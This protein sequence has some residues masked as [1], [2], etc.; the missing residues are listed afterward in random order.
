[1]N[2]T[3]VPGLFSVTL[4]SSCGVLRLVLRAGLGRRDRELD[5]RTRGVW[6]RRRAGDGDGERGGHGE[7]AHEQLAQVGSPL[8]QVYS[9]VQARAGKYN[10]ARREKLRGSARIRLAPAAS[11]GPHAR[12]RARH[13][14]AAVPRQAAVGQRRAA[15]HGQAARPARARRVLGLLP[16]QLAAHAALREGVARA[17]RRRRA[18]RDRRPH[19]RLPPRARDRE[20]GRRRRAARDRV[21]GRDRRA[22]GDL[23]LLRQR[24]LAGALPLGPRRARST[25]CTTARAPTR[26]PSARS[27]RCSASSASSSS[28]CARRTPRAS[29]CRRRPRT[30][31]APTA[32][33][34]RPAARGR[35]SRAPAT[36]TRERA[37][38]HGRARPAAY[39]L[40]RAPPAHRG[41]ARA[42]DRRRRDLPRHVLH[43][44]G[45][46]LRVT[47]LAQQADEPRR[48]AVLEHDGGAGPVGRRVRLGREEVRLVDPGAGV[49]QPRAGGRRPLAGVVARPRARSGACGRRSRAAR[50]I[51]SRPQ[52]LA[53]PAQA[54]AAQRAAGEVAVDRARGPSRLIAADA[55]R[56][57]RCPAPRRAAG[58]APAPP[59]PSRPTRAPTRRRRR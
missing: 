56:R 2:S 29:C 15:A 19:R 42:G 5:R 20:R 35:C 45:S 7:R 23:G 31:R 14:G 12:A 17:L 43:A 18:A 59:P 40:A 48:A 37:H 16:R 50:A 6:A 46:Q 13:P 3:V 8:R 32:G 33:R 44:R 22:A 30:S 51:P 38:V 49:V 11:F 54:A 28:P 26:R 1:M 53:D 39:P 21:P 25:R 27:R 4:K 58:A 34:T 47:P 57:T 36:V 24:G 10:T 41:R 9:G 52:H 55:R